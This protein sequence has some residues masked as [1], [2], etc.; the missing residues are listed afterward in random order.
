MLNRLGE[1]LK[2]E[3][4]NKVNPKEKLRRQVR[5]RE[6]IVIPNK[7]YFHRASMSAAS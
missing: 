5:L 4:T 2:D 7:D 6:D 3:H 1:T